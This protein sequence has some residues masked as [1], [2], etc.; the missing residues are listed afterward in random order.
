MLSCQLII[1]IFVYIY[2]KYALRFDIFTRKIVEFLHFSTLIIHFLCVLSV[3][4]EGILNIRYKIGAELSSA[5][6]L[7]S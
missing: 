2:K 3:I 7:Y 5:P 4:K 6:I 1:S